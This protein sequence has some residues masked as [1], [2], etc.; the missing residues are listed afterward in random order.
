MC[1]HTTDITPGE[2]KAGCER[3]SIC[4][5]GHFYESS[6]PPLPKYISI[7]TLNF[8]QDFQELNRFLQT[9]PLKYHLVVQSAPSR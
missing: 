3:E 2:K 5:T 1:F 9:S 8:G 4:H 7:Y 6:R